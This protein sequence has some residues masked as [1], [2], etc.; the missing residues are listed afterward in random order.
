M[1]KTVCP[2]T[3]KPS[4][5]RQYSTKVLDFRCC[6]HRDCTLHAGLEFI[7]SLS[8]LLPFFFEYLLIQ[9]EAFVQRTWKLPLRVS[10]GRKPVTLPTVYDYVL[11]KEASCAT[12]RVGL[13][14]PALCYFRGCGS[15]DEICTSLLCSVYPGATRPAAECHK[16]T[17]HL[18]STQLQLTAGL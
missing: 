6:D 15:G 17:I 7:N 10:K 3:L 12:D 11:A 18:V 13:R 9:C 1:L 16:L 8:Q 2:T 14:A 4:V 5:L